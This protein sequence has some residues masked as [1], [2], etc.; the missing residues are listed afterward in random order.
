MSVGGGPAGRLFDIEIVVAAK[1]CDLSSAR[2]KLT[3]SATST[4][5]LAASPHW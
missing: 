3:L 5:P 2:V 1:K 4:F